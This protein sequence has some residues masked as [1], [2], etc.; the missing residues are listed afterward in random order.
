MT[1]STQQQVTVVCV[2]CREVIQLGTM[3]AVVSSECE[4]C[5]ADLS[6]QLT[7]ARST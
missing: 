3:V 1:F 4:A 7:E 2:A 5:K 6:E